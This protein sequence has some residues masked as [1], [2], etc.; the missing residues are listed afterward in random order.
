MSVRDTDNVRW[1]VIVSV[2]DWVLVTLGID[3]N[4]AEPVGDCDGE[5]ESVVLPL[6]ERDCDPLTDR[7]SET[8]RVTDT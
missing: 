5:L 2:N 7:S 4:D 1:F 3:E 8:V 6:V